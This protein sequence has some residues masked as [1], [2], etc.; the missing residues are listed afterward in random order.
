MAKQ[1][2]ERFLVAQDIHICVYLLAGF[3]F[4]GIIIGYVYVA[5]EDILQVV[6]KILYGFRIFPVPVKDR[7]LLEPERV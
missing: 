1:V 7:N 6:L 3:K 2:A 4:V 5:A